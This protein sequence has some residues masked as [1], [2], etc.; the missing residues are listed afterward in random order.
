MTM[1]MVAI[2]YCAI[3][4]RGCWD[5][6]SLTLAACEEM[7]KIGCGS[8]S[9]CSHW[10]SKSCR[11][12]RAPHLRLRPAEAPGRVIDA[13][14]LE[15]RRELPY[16]IISDSRLDGEGASGSNYCCHDDRIPGMDCRKSPAP[17]EVRGF[18]RSQAITN[19]SIRESLSGIVPALSMQQWHISR[20]T[21]PSAH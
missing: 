5:R 10:P 12:A 17:R 11:K 21:S 14:T 6:L 7:Q 4:S 9:R 2:I 3:A 18:V 20:S 15:S 19:Y 1:D 16:L 8:S 13:G